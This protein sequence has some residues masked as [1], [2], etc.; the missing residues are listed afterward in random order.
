MG[1]FT[2]IAATLAL[3]GLAA[4]FQ[5]TGP[6]PSAAV[7]PAAAT[8]F[9]P[10]APTTAFMKP[11]ASRAKT[12]ADF[13]ACAKASKSA[14][15]QDPRDYVKACMTKRGYALGPTKYCADPNDMTTPDCVVPAR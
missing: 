15:D 14:P 4:G 5:P 8:T 1:N 9:S 12:Q 11:G 2:R 13:H 6:S 7:P 3:A 10:G